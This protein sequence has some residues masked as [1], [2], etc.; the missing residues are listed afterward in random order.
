MATHIHHK[1]AIKKINNTC[2]MNT[3]ELLHKRHYTIPSKPDPETKFVHAQTL[4]FVTVFCHCIT[5]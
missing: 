3:C 1:N 4:A 5:Q 2:S